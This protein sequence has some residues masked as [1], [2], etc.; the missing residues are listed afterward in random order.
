M[1]RTYLITTT[2]L[3]ELGFI[4]GNVEADVIKNV[5]WRVQETQIQP[6]LG[7]P[8]YRKMKEKIEAWYTG[9]ETQS[10]VYYDLLV[11]YIVPCLVALCEVKIT[12]HL[13]SEI[14]NKGVGSNRDEHFTSNTIAQNN[15][16][17]DELKKDA[18]SFQNKLIKHLCDDN[19]TNYPEYLERTGNSE[20]DVPEESGPDYESRI[21]I[22]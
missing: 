19:G 7:S 1:A 8:L 22:L 13:N 11:E 20:D 15:N 4:D 2:Q 12:F 16:L 6:I 3:T 10:G 18:S 21:S 5:I 14:E 17:R 9:S